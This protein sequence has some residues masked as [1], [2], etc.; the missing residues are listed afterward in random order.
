VW[1]DVFGEGRAVSNSEKGSS[2]V[3]YFGIIVIWW[4]RRREGIL[5]L[6]PYAIAY[7]HERV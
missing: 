7:A 4:G 3:G 5:V 1:D 2:G 6:F